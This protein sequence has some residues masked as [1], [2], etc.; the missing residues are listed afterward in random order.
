MTLSP[1]RLGDTNLCRNLVIDKL[2]DGGA[3]GLPRRVDS[4]HF[5]LLPL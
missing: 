5:L 2:G 3:A 4:L 1:I